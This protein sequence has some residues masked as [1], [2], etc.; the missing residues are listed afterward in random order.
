MLLFGFLTSDL[1]FAI[2]CLKSETESKVKTEPKIQNLKP[3]HLEIL[4][5]N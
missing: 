1:C 3:A 5:T 2:L 4:K